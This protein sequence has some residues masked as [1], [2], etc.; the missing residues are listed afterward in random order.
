MKMALGA[1]AVA[2]KEFEWQKELVHW[3]AYDTIRMNGKCWAWSS[4]QES[5]I[6]KMRVFRSLKWQ[7]KVRCLREQNG[8]NGRAGKEQRQE[9]GARDPLCRECVLLRPR[10][11]SHKHWWN[12][13]NQSVFTRQRKYSN[14]INKCSILLAF[15]FS[16]FHASVHHCVG[17]I[18]FWMK[19]F[20]WWTGFDLIRRR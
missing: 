7:L 6:K 10:K 15:F 13:H 20:V 4:R 8:N 12:L 2:C 14:S 11:N 18:N 9:N 16:V 5:R 17:R 3:P 19:L 1:N